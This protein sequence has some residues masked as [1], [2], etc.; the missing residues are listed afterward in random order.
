MPI[1]EY[2]CGECGRVSSFIVMNT[3]EQLMQAFVDYQEGRF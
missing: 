1:Y 2:R 3:R